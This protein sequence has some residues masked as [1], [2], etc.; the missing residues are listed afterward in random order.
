MSQTHSR[1]APLI[2][3]SGPSGVGKTTVVDRLLAGTNLPLRRAVTA[4]TREPR[5][6]ER[7]G[8]DYHFWTVDEFRRALDDERMLEHAV[9]FGRDFY[10]TPRTEVDEGRA[11]GVGVIL[12]IDVQGAAQVRAKLPDDHLSVFIDPPSIEELEARLRGRKDTTEERIRRRLETA[13]EELKQADLF[14]HRIVN[15][16]LTETVG[17]LERVIRDRFNR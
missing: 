8:T 10:G 15:R 6:G 1:P 13:R 11:R 4:T 9:V 3:V 5:E 16:D 14:H 12:V 7:N 17:E 2:I